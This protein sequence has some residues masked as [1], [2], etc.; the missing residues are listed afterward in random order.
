MTVPTDQLA[1]SVFGAVDWPNLV[2]TLSAAVLGGWIASRIAQRQMTASAEAERD[3]T[4]RE[5]ARDL[6]ESIDSYLHIAYR[7]SG[8]DRFERQR[9][10]RRILSLIALV[11]PAEFTATQNHLDAVELW[12][13]AKTNPTLKPRGVGLTATETFC[14]ALKQRLFAE[15]F[16]TLLVLTQD[17]GSARD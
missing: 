13:R 10:H 16:G 11:M 14:I 1:T 7:G 17:T 4:R 12:W 2:A 9:L 6:I 5:L 3:K 8:E 15:V